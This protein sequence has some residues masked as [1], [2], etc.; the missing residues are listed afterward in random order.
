MKCSQGCEDYLHMARQEVY[1]QLW[2]GQAPRLCKDETSTLPFSSPTSTPATPSSVSHEAT[3]PATPSSL[4]HG[5]LV[6]LPQTTPPTPSSVSYGALVHHSQNPVGGDS[7]EHSSDDDVLDG[8]T[9]GQPISTT[10]LRWL[11]MD[12]LYFVLAKGHARVPIKFQW[13]ATDPTTRKREMRTVATFVLALVSWGK[14]KGAL[15]QT[16]I[17]SK[18]RFDTNCQAIVN[19]TRVRCLAPHL[20]CSHCLF[21]VVTGPGGASSQRQA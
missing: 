21:A 3:T 5:A 12:R 10:K 18:G 9:L 13:H 2:G 14:S 11:V 4:S 19:Q 1:D 15:V 20:Q 7:E 8:V 17:E 6:N 16:L